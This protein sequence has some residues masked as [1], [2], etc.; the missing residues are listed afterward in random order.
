MS[1]SQIFNGKFS[2][3]V[4]SSPLTSSTLGLFAALLI[5]ISTFLNF[6]ITFFNVSVTSFSDVISAFKKIEFVLYFSLIDA[7][8]FLPFTSSISNNI[9][10]PP[11]SAIPQHVY[12]PVIQPHQ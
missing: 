3:R 12:S 7:A 8:T 4:H 6:E 1:S 5:N 11:N 9:V 10:M 2:K